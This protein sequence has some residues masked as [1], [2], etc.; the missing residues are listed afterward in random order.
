MSKYTPVTVSQMECG[1]KIAN[2][3]Q[4]GRARFQKALDDGSFGRFLESLKVELT[5]IEPPQGARVH[6]L[7]VKVQQGRD[8]QEAV[9]AAGPNTPD[10]YN[11]RKVGDQY[12]P[13]GTEVIEEE[14]ILL[15][16]PN[17]DGNWDKA[18]A[19][20]EAKGLKRTNP[21]EAFAVGEQHPKLHEQ[22]GQNPMYVVGTTDCSFEGGRRACC[23][24]W[25]DSGRKA[26][27]PWVEYFS[28]AYGWFA[29]RK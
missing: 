8:W 18:L 27:L 3:K 23:V 5:D 12:P 1:R 26:N 13:V 22:L 25:D 9:N 28:G 19:W 6:V 15:N 4:V 20:A 29:F 17:G 10:H 7:K 11:V 21:R 2:E 16:F 24:W 14:L